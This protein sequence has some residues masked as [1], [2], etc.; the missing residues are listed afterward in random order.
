MLDNMQLQPVTEV[1]AE[2]IPSTTKG[3]SP[4]VITASGHRAPGPKGA[5]VGDKFTYS[6]RNPQSGRR[7]GNNR[8]GRWSRDPAVSQDVSL[9]IGRSAALADTFDFSAASRTVK[10]LARLNAAADADTPGFLSAVVV[11]GQS[12]FANSKSGING[13]RFPLEAFD[14]LAQ[15]MRDFNNADVLTPGTVAIEVIGGFLNAQTDQVLIDWTTD[16]VD[17]DRLA[18]FEAASK[19][20]QATAD[21]GVINWLFCLDNIIAGS[22]AAGA[23]FTLVGKLARSPCLLGQ[24][25]IQASDVL[26]NTIIPGNAGLSINSIEIA[27]YPT[28]SGAGVIGPQSFAAQTANPNGAYLGK[29]LTQAGQEVVITGTNNTPGAVDVLAGIFCEDPDA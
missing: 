21:I 9:P 8:V 4:T 29:L 22:V 18:A 25:V 16:L 15:G 6:K 13:N 3:V 26:T 5:K 14:A 23:D 1:I 12:L 11:A 27:G 28:F 17:L 20:G 7:G 10:V 19:G 2:V 24:V